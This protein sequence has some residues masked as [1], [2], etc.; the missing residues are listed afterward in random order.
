VTGSTGST[1]F[2]VTPGVFDTELGGSGP[3]G[4]ITKIQRGGTALAYSSYLGG[5][6]FDACADVEVDADGQVTVV[7]TTG[8][9]DFPVTPGAF[10]ESINGGTDA[11]ASVVSRDASD[12]I[13]STFVGGSLDDLAGGLDVDAG[14]G[15]Y[16]VGETLSSD[17]PTTPGSFDDTYNRQEDGFVAKLAPGP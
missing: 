11:F 5:K 6:D 15:V 4:F 16:V 12:L 7:G 13:A 10:D 17:F 1:D 2:P 9:S 3:D 8:S 14:G